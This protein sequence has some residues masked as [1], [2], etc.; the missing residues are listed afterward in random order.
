[1]QRIRTYI[2]PIIS[3]SLFLLNGL[4]NTAHGANGIKIFAEE[5]ADKIFYTHAYQKDGAW[6]SDLYAMNP[7]GTEPTQVTDFYPANAS[8]ATIS[9]DGK[10]LYFTSNYEFY[11]SANYED[12]F[13]LEFA[14]LKL[15][16]ITGEEKV[17]AK[18][19]GKV[20]PHVIDDTGRDILGDKILVSFQGCTNLMTMKEMID[21]EKGLENVPATKVWIKAVVDRFTGSV[22]YATVPAVEGGVRVDLTLTDG[23][24]LAYSSTSSPDG[25]KIAGISGHAFYDPELKDKGPNIVLSNLTIWDTSGKMLDQQQTSTAGD[26]YPEYSPDGTKIAYTQGTA[27]RIQWLWWQ[28]I[29]SMEHPRL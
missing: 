19:T 21:E 29:T 8:E 23:N 15:T 9:K 1:M 27:G 18:K 12:I 2:L 16:R 17:S 22:V 25:T 14:G 26:A 4:L 6:F 20:G 13:R 10:S 3:L 28:A 11:K 24:Y 7:D 5:K